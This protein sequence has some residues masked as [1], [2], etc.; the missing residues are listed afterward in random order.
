M[1]REGNIISLSLTNFQTFSSQT[2]NFGPF[3]NLIAAPN[4]SGKSSLANA[5]ALVFNGS[6]RTIGKSKEI[7]E[8]IKFGCK[9]AEISAGVWFK[10]RIIQLTR[11]ITFNHS[12]FY[13]NGE[14]T[15]QKKYSDLIRE[16]QIDISSLCTFLP[17]ERVGEFCKM[18]PRELFNEVIKNTGVDMTT[19][20]S[21]YDRRSEICDALATNEEKKKLLRTRLEILETDMKELQEYEEN[22]ERLSRLECQRERVD[23]IRMKGEYVQMRTQVNTLRESLEEAD[24]KIAMLRTEI[25]ECEGDKAL[26]E[27]KKNVDILTAQNERLRQLG[28]ALKRGVEEVEMHRNER[29]K[30]KKRMRERRGEVEEKEKDYRETKAE[31][32]RAEEELARE[33][34]QFR[35]RVIE[36]CSNPGYAGLVTV[37]DM[38]LKA[39]EDIEAFTPSLRRIEDKIQE[40][41]MELSRIQSISKEIQNRIEGLERQKQV[42]SG[43]DSLRMDMLRKYHADTQKAVLWLRENRDIFEDEVLE[44][45][46]LHLQVDEAYVR[47]VEPF[48]GFQ[49]LSSFIVKNEADFTLFTSHLKD[50]QGLSVNAAMHSSCRSGGIPRESIR[51]FGLDGVLTDF[52][53]CRAEYVDFLNNYGHFNAIPVSIK[54]INEEEIFFG[55][56][57]CRRMAVGSRYSE[58]KRSRYSDDY[59]IITN[60]LAQKGLFSFPKVDL[61]GITQQMEELQRER[62]RNRTRVEGILE[63]KNELGRKKAKLKSEFDS[64]LVS[65]IGFNM[66]R[67]LRNMEHTRSQIEEL[68]RTDYEE[69]V[70]RKGEEIAKGIEG[71][72]VVFTEM[73]EVLDI[74]NTPGFDIEKVRTLKLDI[75]NL[76]RQMHYFMHLKSTHEHELAEL[77]E[78]RGRIKAVLLEMKARLDMEPRSDAE[79][80]GMSVE[81]IEGE[82]DFLR[83]K[84]KLGGGREKIKEDY[85]TKQSLLDRVS[86]EVTDLNG[87]KSEL[88]RMYAAEK[89]AIYRKLERKTSE[90]SQVFM[91]LFEKFGYSGRLELDMEKREWELKV[92]VKFRENEALQQLSSF[93]QSGGEKSLATALFLLSLQQCETAPFRLVDEINQGMD[94]TNERRVFEVLREM[95]DVAQIFII[96]PKLIEGIEFSAGARAIVIYGGPGI[97]KEFERYTRSVLTMSNQ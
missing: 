93:R 24:E 97:S 17:Q 45:L 27:Y 50:K 61:E 57:E 46:Y 49:A 16:I 85:R 82:I 35:S 76:M 83:S 44:P 12:Y 96:T 43:Q 91:R 92:L 70:R 87:S 37:N 74:E 73:E 28:T 34:K 23:F 90:L 78:E 41:G 80:A 33:L 13:I 64:S 2:F 40:W 53:H 10:N 1:Y 89:E 22:V 88:E 30:A 32:E 65:R 4:G 14:L 8:Y 71:I 36:I 55:I 81:E 6:P 21:L 69:A 47:Y 7:A 20:K 95:G 58:I 39:P 31:Y 38:P 62:E 29:E 19:I 72:K 3:L 84:V 54:E 52:I 63:A 79:I 60:R 56:P 75:D 42:Y 25:D 51:R 48:L 86:N 68:R 26:V 66:K 15:T 11:K 9:E 77:E 5:I 59:T 94:E 67:L 18:D